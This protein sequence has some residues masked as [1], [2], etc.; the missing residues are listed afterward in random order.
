[1]AITG[2]G[3]VDDPYLVHSYEELKTPVTGSPTASDNNTYVKLANDINCNDYGDIW[4]WG[5]ITLSN[6]AWNIDLDG[7]TIK[8]IMIKSENSLFEGRK[9]GQVI[10]NGKILNVFNNSGECIVK[11]DKLKLKDISMSVNGAGLTG[12]AFNGIFIEN[13]TIYF[14]INKLNDYFYYINS[15]SNG[16]IKNSDFYFEINN[17]NSRSLFYNVSTNNKSADNCRFRGAVSGM[18]NTGYLLKNS[19]CINS[20]VE[21]DTTDI[22]WNSTY[23]TPYRVP[24]DGISTG[25]INTEIS[26]NM[27]GGTSGLTACTTAQMRDADYLNSIGF[28]VVKVG[29]R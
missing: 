17:M 1:M 26:P 18:C 2:T 24:C 4:E 19:G 27:V 21:I 14:K 15:G 7:H 9:E 12:K 8:N 23:D 25:I 6:Y 10:H 28:T 20:V 22:T 29:E 5:T 11:G 16:L 13:C 3:A